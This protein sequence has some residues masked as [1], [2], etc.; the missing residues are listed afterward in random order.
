M[1][2]SLAKGNALFEAVNLDLIYPVLLEFLNILKTKET[3]KLNRL[4]YQKNL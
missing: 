2:V 4:M 1:S 3:G